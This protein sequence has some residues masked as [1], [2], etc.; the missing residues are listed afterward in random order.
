MKQLNILWGKHDL[1]SFDPDFY[2]LMFLESDIGQL[3]IHN[4]VDYA[5]F[6]YEAE[7]LQIIFK[8]NEFSDVVMEKIS[9]EVILEFSGDIHFHVV[10][11]HSKYP[12]DIKTLKEFKI[13]KENGYTAILEFYDGSVME[14]KSK[15][16]KVFID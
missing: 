3:D 14:I 12:Q 11:K 16:F 10:P 15:H 7:R 2:H 5:G 6:I 1:A 4:C 8:R 13:S 9:N